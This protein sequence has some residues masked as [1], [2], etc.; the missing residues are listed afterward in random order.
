MVHRC[1]WLLAALLG[2]LALPVPGDSANL[3][4]PA[5]HPRIWYGNAARLAQARTYFA[6]VPFTPAGSDATELNMQRA[7]RGLLNNSNAD[8]D[9]AVAHLA[10]WRWETQGVGR[11]DALRQQ[12][13]GLLA[14]YDWCRNRLSPTQ[15]S[16]LVSL[17]NGYMDA[18]NADDF[19]NDGSEANN[20]F[21]GRVR[22]N[23]MWGI[24][25]FGDNP[26]AQQF[27]DHALDVRYGQWFAGWYSD[28]GR[29]GNFAEGSDY[30]VV[31]LSYPLLPFASA[32][33][34]GFDPWA[35]S[36]FFRE[37]IY[38]VLYG[39]TPG[40]SAVTG[41]FS[42]APQLFPFCDDDSFRDG[43][44]INNRQYLGD[45]ARYMG[46]RNPT[47]GNARAARAWLS[48]TNAGR[49]W[50]FDAL[51]GTGNVAD[52]QSLP[53]DYWAPGAG[54]LDA[55][56]AHDA[57]TTQ[58]HVQIN[59]PGGTEHRHLDA[60]S[61]QM[62]RKGRWI[63]RESA[64]YSASIA[65]FG[66]TGSVDTA[67]PVAHNG[68]LFQGRST[69]RWIGTGPIVI[70]PGVDR[71]DQPDGLPTV[72]RLQHHPEFN[73][74]VADF[75][76]SYRNTNGRRVDWP[77]A[78]R[79]VR[80]FLFL[81][82]L[83]ALIVFDRTRGSSDSTLP[84]YFTTSWNERTDPLAVHVQGAQVVRT[85]I[86]HFETQPTIAGNR[87]SAT[88][89][90]QVSDLVSLAP[91]GAT[92][93]LIN[94]DRPGSEAEGQYRIEIDSSGSLESYF[95]NVVHGRDSG[96]AALT[97]TVTEAADRYTVQ[98]A[99]S[100]VGSATVVLMKG[101][102]SVGGSVALDGGAAIPLSSRVQGITVTDEGPVWQTLDIQFEDGF[103]TVN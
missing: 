29:G 50:M 63:T 8:C 3:T 92:L 97:A 48:T 2:L 43:G 45:F 18:E 16:T 13:E 86:S 55:R 79:A 62:W 71:G 58:V 96:A 98:L 65:G 70:P 6:S 57:N 42:G 59:T 101:M 23:L 7:L 90:N 32:A 40:P 12:G 66:G 89:G 83:G 26:R 41:G 103:E 54:V 11:R 82:D 53:L 100:G 15:V 35:A 75:S 61:F 93:R 99:Q 31:M 28:F 87:A 21:W 80:E 91:A 78:D 51:G 94:E 17:W 73:F 85:F 14:I 24:A 60:G 1:T 76:A 44:V 52:I 22:N 47:T 84:F 56:S 4:I 49:G 33:D 20:Y 5:S 46:T 102:S 34:F 88:V 67:S 27:I 64:G 68:L 25:S 38:A 37:A 39:T 19:A 10:A 81:R 30:G 95:L 72:V 74:L 36:P 77:Y 9:P 69:A